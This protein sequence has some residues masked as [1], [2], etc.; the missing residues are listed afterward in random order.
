ML[1]GGI[2][3][4]AAACAH[5]AATLDRQQ[6]WTRPLRFA[7]AP[8]PSWTHCCCLC[9]L[10]DRAEPRPARACARGAPVPAPL[11]RPYAS[12]KWSLAQGLHRAAALPTR[13]YGHPWIYMESLL[14]QRA[15]SKGLLYHAILL[16]HLLYPRPRLCTRLLYHDIAGAIS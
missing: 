11:A 5:R 6:H 12:A 10:V 15:I 9:R 4:M 13:I 2:L 7:A 16:Y 8:L 3:G 1:S 14:Y